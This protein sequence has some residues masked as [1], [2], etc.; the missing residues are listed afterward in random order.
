MYKKFIT[1]IYT[2]TILFQSFFSLLTPI[3]LM[4][5][6]A[7]LLNTYAGVEAWIFAVFILIGVFIGLYSMISFIIKASRA[8]EYLEREARKEERSRSER[9]DNEG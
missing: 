4:W 1:P 8:L 5:L 7:W 6:F 2:V 9:N 3:G